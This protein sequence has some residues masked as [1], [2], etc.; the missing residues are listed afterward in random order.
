MTNSEEW[1]GKMADNENSILKESY[2]NMTLSSS[3]QQPYI[4]LIDMGKII[5]HK[6]APLTSGLIM[7]RRYHL[8]SFVTTMLL[9]SS[10]L[11][12][13]MTQ[14]TPLKMTSEGS[15]PQYLHKIQ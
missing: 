11:M 9:V 7:S 12:T 2:G 15:C 8:S 3:V 14:P 13:H 1:Y 10:V 5:R 4:A 6:M